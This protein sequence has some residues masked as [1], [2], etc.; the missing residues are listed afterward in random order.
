MKEKKQYKYISR[1]AK[2]IKA[3]NHLGGKCHICGKNNIFYL[4]FHHKIS[5]KKEKN[6][7]IFLNNLSHWN[8]IA[9]ELNKCILTCRNCHKEIHTGQNN[10][11]QD[12]KKKLMEYKKANGCEKCGYIGKNLGSL[13]F[14]H[15]SNKKFMIMKETCKRKRILNYIKDEVD[16]CI[17]LCSNCHNLEHSD[18][19]R[20]EKNKAEIYKHMGKTKELKKIDKNIVFKMHRDGIRN[21]DIARKLKCAK[22]SITYLI[23]RYV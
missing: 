18:I 12:L 5:Q 7:S 9:K 19:T 20:F 6:I 15:L 13:D 8:R 2:K 23:K 3:I 4:E 1:F 21:I 17:I 22:S 14:H 11:V 16:K 10:R